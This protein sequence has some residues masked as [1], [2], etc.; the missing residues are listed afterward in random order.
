MPKVER[1]TL[2]DF[3]THSV[4]KFQKIEGEK[5]LRKKSGNAEK[6]EKGEPLVSSGI[7]CYAGNLFGNPWANRG[8]LKFCRTFVRTILVTAGVSKKTLT[9]SHDYSRLFSQGKRPLKYRKV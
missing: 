7:V 2:W 5:L 4:A 1:G 8:N 6:T 9:E 3:S